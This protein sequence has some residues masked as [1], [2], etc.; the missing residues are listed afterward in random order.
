MPAPDSAK[1]PPGWIAPRPL[2]RRPLLLALAVVLLV[3]WLAFLSWLAWQVHR[4]E[5]QSS[6]SSQSRISFSY[7][8]ARSP[9]TNC[10]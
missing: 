8:L 3:V 9:L 10:R 2:K 4:R 1:H 7:S 5:V 6:S